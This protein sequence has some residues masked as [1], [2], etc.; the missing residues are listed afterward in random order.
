MVSI[1]LSLG[2][3]FNHYYHLNKQEKTETKWEKGSEKIGVSFNR[4]H[5]HNAAFSPNTSAKK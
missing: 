4:N 3:Y 1:F 5:F 2:S